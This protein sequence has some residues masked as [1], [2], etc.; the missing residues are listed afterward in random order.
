MFIPISC[1]QSSVVIKRT[2]RKHGLLARG[3]NPTP[4]KFESTTKHHTASLMY[5]HSEYTTVQEHTASISHCVP[6]YICTGIQST[7]LCR[8]IQLAS[9]TVSL[10]I[11]VQAFRVQYTLQNKLRNYLYLKLFSQNTTFTFHNLTAS[12][13]HFLTTSQPHYVTTLHVC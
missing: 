11:H 10:N 4:L 13:C 6:K 9:H 8:N 1:K 3:S 12:P 2:V 7:G 5:R